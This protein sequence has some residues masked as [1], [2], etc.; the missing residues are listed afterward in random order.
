MLLDTWI[1]WFWSSFHLYSLLVQLGIHLC[2]NSLALHKHRSCR[3][4][5]A[6]GPAWSMWDIWLK[7]GD[8]CLILLL[9][10]VLLFFSHH[11]LCFF[12]HGLSEQVGKE[13][14]LTNVSFR[15]LRRSKFEG[16]VSELVAARLACAS[17]GNFSYHFLDVGGWSIWTIFCVTRERRSVG[18]CYIT[19]LPCSLL[20]SRSA[21][22]LN[23]CVL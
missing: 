17:R 1:S 19:P 23:L 16:E 13:S 12:A 11:I 7:K 14:W 3:S 15:R 2:Y 4:S 6:F 9:R 18:S 10:I 20:L 5:L 21:L 8:C 22:V